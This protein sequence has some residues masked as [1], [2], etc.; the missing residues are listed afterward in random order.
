MSTLVHVKYVRNECYNVSM[1]FD[2]RIAI[3]Q[4]LFTKKKKWRKYVKAGYQKLKQ[5]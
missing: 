5:I 2:F 4:I 3:T 1:Q